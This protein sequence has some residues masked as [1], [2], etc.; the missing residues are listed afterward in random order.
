AAAFAAA[1]PVKSFL[2]RKARAKRALPAVKKATRSAGEKRSWSPGLIRVWRTCVA[3]VS[4]QKKPALRRKRRRVCEGSRR[5]YGV[6]NNR[7]H[8]WSGRSF[9]HARGWHVGKA[10]SQGG[11]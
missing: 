10:V 2:C 6:A 9:H 3:G 8:C 7:D 11:P 5:I 4:L 1:A